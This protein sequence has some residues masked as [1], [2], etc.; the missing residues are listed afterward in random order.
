MGNPWETPPKH[1]SFFRFGF[2][3]AGNCAGNPRNPWETQHFVEET[4]GNPFRTM[5]IH[6]PS[7]TLL[8]L[9]IGLQKRLQLWRKPRKPLGNPWE[10]QHF[11]EE[12]LRNPHRTM[13]IHPLAIY[14]NKERV[15][16]GNLDEMQKSSRPL[17]VF[18]WHCVPRC[19]PA[20]KRW[21][22]GRVYFWA[23]KGKK[24]WKRK[25]GPPQ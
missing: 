18:W 20:S 2:K 21:S 10:T 1:Y 23:L 14:K 8:F 7:E 22:F 6:P 13:H 25:F 9:W 3:N 19:H 5:H 17:I 12:T 24:N 15:W 4:F 16:E 11:V